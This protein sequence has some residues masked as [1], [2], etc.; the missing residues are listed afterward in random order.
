MTSSGANSVRPSR[1]MRTPEPNLVTAIAQ[2]DDVVAAQCEV[3]EG[4]G[5]TAPAGHVHFLGAHDVRSGAHLHAAL[6][7]G[8]LDERDFQFDR[9]AGLKITWSEE[10]NA[11]GADVAGYERDRN[12]LEMIIDARETERQRERCAWIVTALARNADSVRGNSRKTLWP[13]LPVW[14]CNAYG[15]A[16]NFTQR[17]HDR[18]RPLPIRSSPHVLSPKNS[19]NF[20]P[21]SRANMRGV[22]NR[23]KGSDGRVPYHTT[24]RGGTHSYD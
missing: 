20:P 11:T 24:V 7:Q 22:W 12:G 10:I 4:G 17:R 9:G 14:R 16:F 19:L 1:R 8:P 13:R 2:R 15:V 21:A 5:V 18:P 23:V 3:I 6:A